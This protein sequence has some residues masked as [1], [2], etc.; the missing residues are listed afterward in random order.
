ML[1]L[2]HWKLSP[3]GGAVITTFL[4]SGC[5]HHR[6]LARVELKLADESAALTT[7]VVD[8]LA[9]QPESDRD[10]FSGTALE[11]AKQDQRIEGLPLHPI[12]VPALLG[13]VTAVE[14]QA[15]QQHLTNRFVAQEKLLKARSRHEIALQAAG[16]QKELDRGRR[17]TFWSKAVALLGL[18]L[19][20][21]IALCVFMP[22]MIPIVGR[23][24][25]WV[26]SKAPSLAGAVGVVG[27]KAFD[28]VVK[29]IERTRN[30]PVAPA[31]PKTELGNSGLGDSRRHKESAPGQDEGLMGRLEAELSRAMDRGEKA[32][33]RSRKNALFAAA[34]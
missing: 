7:A 26:V 19:A 25:G 4:L 21:L 9:A 27:V 23:L 20:G 18:P 17:F 32:L 10:R 33:V 6:G 28:A 12:N 29:G 1:N 14:V 11:L 22:A 31:I 15:A 8:A 34:H 24:A 3:I 13:P 2:K 30:F 5:S 16:E